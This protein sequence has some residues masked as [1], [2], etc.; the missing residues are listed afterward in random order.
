VPFGFFLHDRGLEYMAA[1]AVTE[2]YR[3][4]GVLNSGGYG[5]VH[6][7]YHIASGTRVAIKKVGRRARALSN[8]S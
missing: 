6:S 8:A 5:E 7:G 4:Q 3:L 2:A 1:P